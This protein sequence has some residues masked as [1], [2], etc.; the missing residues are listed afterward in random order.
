MDSRELQTITDERLDSL[1]RWKDEQ[2][3]KWKEA[4]PAGDHQ[5]HARY[6]AAMIE[7]ILWKRRLWQQLVEKGVGALALAFV[8]GLLAAGWQWIKIQL[9]RG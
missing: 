4:F 8:L 5:A 2:E 7:N 1:E 9:G 6:H 3:A